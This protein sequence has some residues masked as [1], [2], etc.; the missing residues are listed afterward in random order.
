[1]FDLYDVKISVRSIVK[2]LPE[3]KGLLSMKPNHERLFR[4]TIFGP[5]LDIQS[6]ENNSHMMH[7]VFQ[8]QV[9]ISNLRLNCPPII[10]HIGDHWLEFGRK[11]FCLIT[12]FRFAHFSEKHGPMSTFFDRYF[13]E[14]KTRNGFKKINGFDLLN[15]L[16]DKKTWLNMLDEDDVRLCLLIASELV[17]MGKEKRNFLTKHIMWLVDDFDAWND[18]PWGE[19]MWEKF[20]NR[21]VTV[22]SRHTEHHLAELKKNLNFSGTYNL[23][24]F[25]WHSRKTFGKLKISPKETSQ[26]WFKASA[27]FIKGLD[28]QDNTFFQDDKGREKCIEQHNGMCGDT[29]DGTFVDGVVGKIC[30]KMN[31]MLVDDGDGVLDSQSDDRD[32]VL[33]SQTKDEVLL[34]KRRKDDKFDELT[35]IF[36]KL[37]TS[38]TFVKEAKLFFPSIVSSHPIGGVSSEAKAS[39]S[40]AHPGNDEDVSHLD[41]NMEIDGQNAKDGYSNSQHHLHLLIKA[42]GTKIENPSID[43]VVPPKV[44]DPMLRTIKP[45][46]DFDEADVDSYDDDYMSLFNDEEQPAKSSLNDL[47]LQREPDIVDVK[48]GILEQQANAD[49][50]KT[51]VIQET[52][53]V[54]VEERPS[55][56]RHCVAFRFRG[57]LTDQ[58]LDLWIDLMWSLRPPE[59]DWAIVSPHFSTCILN[60]MMQD[61]FSNGHMYPLPWIAVE[62]VYFPVNEPKEHW[63]LAQLEIRTGVVTFYDSL[64]WAGGSRRRWWRR[65][66][67]V[68]PEKL[69]LYLLMHG[70]FD[71][72]GISADHYKITYNYASVLFQAS[73][74]DECGI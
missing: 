10:F 30:P 17:F 60:G 23:Y 42:L 53:R 2:L 58:H 66:K 12:G 16:K 69:T 35:K 71:S 61:Y 28:D 62:K 27:E 34:I 14:N 5:W 63:C 19:Y 1:M 40:S 29:E 25:A 7:Y 54:I 56:R 4:D 33:D 9:S 55:L 39:S 36:S 70:I 48:D 64:G 67:K 24:G 45:K 51:T 57:W 37:E 6:Y 18:F 52:V 73:L 31:R 22:V 32:G 38:E 49:K 13:S 21:T 50:G 68:L 41:D 20:Y 59:A 15:V 11:E 26:A 43:V 47:E 3:I 46:D 74:Y 72:K 8:H 44:D 65:M